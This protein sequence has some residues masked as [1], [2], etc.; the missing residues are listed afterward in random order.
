[1]ASED[2]IFGVKIAGIGIALPE[3]VVTNNDIAAILE[4]QR[5]LVLAEKAL[6]GTILTAEQLKEWETDDDWIITRTGIKSRHFAKDHE[7]TS[8]YTC[9]SGHNAITD[10]YGEGLGYSPD[11]NII[12]TVSPDHFTTPTTSVIATRKMGLS[13]IQRISRSETMLRNLIAFDGTQACSSFL[14]MLLMGVSLIRSGM[15]QRGLVH[16]SDLMSRTMSKNKRSPYVI[17]G[18]GSG[19]LALENTP[20][21]ESWIGPTA[22]TSGVWG[23]KDGEYEQMIITQA[24]GATTPIT[25]EHIDPLTDSHLMYMDGKGV[26]MKIVPFVAS[27]VIPDALTRAGLTLSDI[28]VIVLHQANHRMT[29][30]VCLRLMIKYG[31]CE[32]R[33]ANQNDLEGVLPSKAKAPKDGHRIVCYNTIDHTGNLTSASIPVG[34]YEA[35]EHGIIVPG[36]RVLTVVFGGGFSWATCII[37]WGG[38]N[39]PAFQ[40]S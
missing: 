26:Y 2:K 12:A 28:D 25:P 20:I 39:H 33:L 22:F 31:D 10:A 9:E 4:A 1:M 36:K 21:K 34:L 11:F 24:G 7:T 27:Q 8:D 40:T 30:A 18:D 3:W 32:I 37:E 5:D 15:A 23:G 38:R 35:R 14:M 16:G 13:H 17:L 6:Q 19:T 29:D